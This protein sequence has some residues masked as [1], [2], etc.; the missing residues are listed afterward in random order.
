MIKFKFV[1]EEKNMRKR[2][3]PQI[4]EEPPPAPPPE[5]KKVLSN[6]ELAKRIEL[7]EELIL[8]HTHSPS[9]AVVFYPDVS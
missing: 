5:D 4:T 1:K 7:L 8:T 6:E 9:G 2:I 3:D